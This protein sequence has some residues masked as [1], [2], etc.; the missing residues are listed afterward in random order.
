M[1]FQVILD[2]PIRVNTPWKQVRTVGG[3]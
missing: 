1:D 3:G 2:L